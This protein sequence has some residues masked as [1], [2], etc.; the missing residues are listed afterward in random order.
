[1]NEAAMISETIPIGT[2]SNLAVYMVGTPSVGVV[3]VWTLL[4]ASSCLE[5]LRIEVL[6]IRP[7]L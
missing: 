5:N 6:I 1:M 4:F 2:I 7:H 3:A